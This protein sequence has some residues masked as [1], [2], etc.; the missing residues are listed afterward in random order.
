MRFF[1][2]GEEAQNEITKIFFAI[3]ALISK[4]SFISAIIK[5]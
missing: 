5:P 4:F 3:G 2:R 1:G